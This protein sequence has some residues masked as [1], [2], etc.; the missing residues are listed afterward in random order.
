MLIRSIDIFVSLSLTAIVG[1][2]TAPICDHG[3]DLWFCAGEKLITYS[4][5]TSGYAAAMRIFVIASFILMLA[6]CA[7]K[8]TVSEHQCRAGDWY[9]VG[10]H[11]GSR[12][13]ERSQLLRHQEACGQHGIYLEREEYMAGWDDGLSQ[14]C[15]MNNAFSLGRR[16]GKNRG[17]CSVEFNAAFE[18]GRRLYRAN[19]KVLQLEKELASTQQRIADIRQELVGASTAQLTPDLTTKERVGLLA[20]VERL[21]Q[22]RSQ[23]R[24]ELPAM[25]AELADRRRYLD[26]LTQSLA[27][28]Y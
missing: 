3:L 19:Q 8:P 10:Y 7:T 15:T 23:L 24:A 4:A 20:K 11:D 21:Y 14:F 22:E 13:L 25:K 12:G 28:G 2:E 16:G 1:D 26:T 27:S 9:T 18:E 6:A 17:L 5:P